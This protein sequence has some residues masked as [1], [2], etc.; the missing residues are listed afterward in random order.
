MDI[1]KNDPRRYRRIVWCFGVP[2]DRT[3]FVAIMTKR[4]NLTIVVFIG[5]VLAICVLIKPVLA[6]VASSS[7]DTAS[8]SP[9]TD[10]DVASTT[11]PADS[12]TSTP[13]TSSPGS[14][15]GLVQVQLR[16]SMSYTG[17]LYDTPSGHLDD[18]YFVGDA[19]AS[20]TGMTEAHLLGQQA[21]T[22]CHD[23][24]DNQHEFKLTAE[25]YAALAKEG[26]PDE[27][28]MEPADQ[29]ALDSFNSTTATTPSSGSSQGSGSS[30]QPPSTAA[31]QQETPDN[32][33]S[34]S[35]TATDQQSAT[36]S[37]ASSSI[38][39]DTGTTTL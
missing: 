23:A 29:A 13:P 7:P 10:T 5:V 22:V 25:Q 16:C 18:G 2:H 8:T 38:D 11:P 24:R 32:T 34:T 19:S 12:S 33:A 15:S 39:V 6:Q 9:A 28:V 26:M 31:P 20:T 37:S 3:S 4:I 27:S 21:W 17:L 1:K 14:S 30:S 36:T 35:Q